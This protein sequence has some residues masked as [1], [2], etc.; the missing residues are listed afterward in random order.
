[1]WLQLRKLRDGFIR[2]A[3]GAIDGQHGVAT[4]LKIN[5]NTIYY[6]LSALGLR[7]EDLRDQALT[8]DELM[9]RSH[10]LYGLSRRIAH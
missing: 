4:L 3:R 6:Q 5:R 7:A 10:G 8:L 1:M 9:R 2:S